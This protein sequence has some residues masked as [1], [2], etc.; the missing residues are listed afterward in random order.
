MS[1]A[2][3]RNVRPPIVLEKAHVTLQ[4]WHPSGCPFKKIDL[5]VFVITCFKQK[6]WPEIREDF[7]G[8]NLVFSYLRLSWQNLQYCRQYWK[9][10]SL[11][12]SVALDQST[13]GPLLNF[14]KYYKHKSKSG[15]AEIKS[16]AFFFFFCLQKTK[17]GFPW[18][19]W[20]IYKKYYIAILQT[21]NWQNFIHSKNK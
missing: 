8:V 4:S 20:K 12:C 14:S 21:L 9:P 7:R 3:P 1:L 10:L 17:H 13:K 16:K 11:N 19:S 15:Y 6:E 5:E 18:Y 2:F